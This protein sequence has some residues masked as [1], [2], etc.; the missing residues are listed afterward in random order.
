MR[1]NGKLTL[2]NLISKVVLIKKRL[3]N[4]L[5]IKNLL[6]KEIKFI[7]RIMTLRKV[8][9]KLNIMSIMENAHFVFV[10]SV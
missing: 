3:I 1:R 9:K 7:C 10:Q 8:P 5:L 2:Y 6:L 4:K